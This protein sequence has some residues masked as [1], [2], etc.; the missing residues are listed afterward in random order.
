MS[1]MPLPRRVH[2]EL[3]NRCNSECATC[4][5][6]AAPP[7]ERDLTVAEVARL[8]DDLPALQ[9]AALQVN[10]E[11]LLYRE[12]GAIIR[13]LRERCVAVELNTNGI[14]LEGDRAAELLAAAPDRL[15]VSIDGATPATYA[16]L[17]GVDAFHRVV[18]NVADFLRL[19]GPA[20]ASPRVSIWMVATRT[21]LH[22]L[23]ALVELAARIRADEVF[24]QRLVVFGAG[25][26]T[27]AE[28][29]HGQLTPEDRDLL[30]SASARAARLGIALAAS[31]G[32]T[33]AV[34]LTPE[35]DSEPW[36]HCRRP[37]ESTAILAD[38]TVVPCCIATFIAPI[39]HISLGNA[40]RDG[41]PAV[42]NAPAYQHFR[43]QLRAGSGPAFCRACGLRWS[44]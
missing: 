9:S 23:P 5:R 2:L 19:R 38:G 17:R 6:T 39:A 24:V 27:E 15:N 13:L 44:L 22:E 25:A 43:T 12:L 26:A 40:L 36:R 14:A 3:T 29:V 4:A 31:G 41:L 20:P 28:S 7:P 11:P 1:T 18:A 10:G 37:A 32:F 16:R 42:W 30:A 35:A 21:T 34:M 33:P 8:V